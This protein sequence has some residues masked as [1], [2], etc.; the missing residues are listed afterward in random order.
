MK[1]SKSRFATVA[2]VGLAL[3]CA[4][5]ATPAWAERR[6]IDQ[7]ASADPQGQIEIVNV[8]GRVAVVGWDKPEVEVTGTLGSDIGKLDIA[9]SGTRTTIRVVLDESHGRHWGIGLHDPG[10]ADLTVYAPR[11]SSLTASLV[12]SDISVRDLQGEQ[13]LQTVS[14]EVRTAALRAVRVHTVS[15]DVH[16]NAGPDSGL[17]EIGTVSGDLDVTGGHGDITISTVSG[18]GKLSLG[19][20]THARLKA[21]SG[22]YQLAMALATD[23]LLEVQ[24]V[25]GDVVVDFTNGVPPA[26]FDLHSFSG[27][28]KACFGQKAEHEHYGPGSRL[29]YR[30]GAG[31]ARVRIDTHSGDVSLCTRPLTGARAA[32]PDALSDLVRVGLKFAQGAGSCRPVIARPINCRMCLLQS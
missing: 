2:C 18:T 1:L 13:E 29:W 12:S 22:D 32:G 3:S 23:G 7:H 8:S 5:G 9:S 10:D 17:L 30:E 27:D 31:S 16:V 21:V 26:D 28:L 6:A 24:S 19:T 11:G 14:G 4:C 25:S 20:V 15:G